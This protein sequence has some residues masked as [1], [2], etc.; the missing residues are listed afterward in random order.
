MRSR[1]AE[2]HIDP[3]RVGFVGFSAGARTALSVGLTSLPDARPD[4]IAPIYG[5]LSA[6]NLPEFAPPMFTAIAADDP[7]FGKTGFD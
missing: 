3:K 4:F 1:A 2:W 6:E 5:P 7:F